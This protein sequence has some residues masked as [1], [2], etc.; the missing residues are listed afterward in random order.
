MI[1][2]LKT[3]IIAAWKAGKEILEVYNNEFS[4]T[5]KEDKSP[6]TEAD[7]RSHAVI[8]AALE[9][10][11]YPILSEEG[12]MTAFEERS[13]WGRFWLVDPLDGT[14]EFIKRNGEFTVNIALIENGRP[15]LGV[16]YVPVASKMY[17]GTEREGSFTF[18]VNGNLEQEFDHHISS[19][20]KLPL[21]EERKTYTIVSSRT[22]T[23]PE[24]ETFINQKSSL[25]GDVNLV[26]AGSSLKLCLVAEGKADVYPRLAPTMEWDTAA[27]HAIVNFAGGRVYR[28]DSNEDLLYNKANLLNPFFV[29]E[30]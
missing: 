9:T 19:S 15:V 27:G 24:T 5:N 3:A 13:N 21:S 20:T 16:I 10:T 1:E 28:Y 14:K 22:H 25:H 12:K 11:P 29:A 8:K 2:V 17:Y 7:L 30:L 26:N 23:S 6:L 4:F 18:T